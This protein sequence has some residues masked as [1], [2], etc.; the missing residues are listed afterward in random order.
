MQKNCYIIKGMP[1]LFDNEKKTFFMEE[2][3]QKILEILKLNQKI[4]V[5]ELCDYFGVSSSTIRTDLRDL[6][7]RGLL[8]RTHGGAI[9]KSKVNLETAPEK[10]LSLMIE[11]KQNIARYAATLVDDG[12]IIAISSGTTTYEFTKQLLKK[13][14]LRIIVNDVKLASFLE[15]NTNFSIFILGGIIR[16]G[17]HYTST[18]ENN[19]LNIFFDKV[20]FSCNGLTA[21]QGATVPDFA[22][23]NNIRNLIK[24]SA[25]SI[26]LCDNSKIGNFFFSQIAPISDISKIICDSDTDHKTIEDILKTDANK[27]IIV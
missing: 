22:L 4:V 12:D 27:V 6:E 21:E 17:F 11:Q 1:N 8:R 2:R 3:Q 19:K 5:P 15:E 16:N 7:E 25:E 20:F 9:I 14:D 23:A 13:N 24:N 10:K 18:L 26:L